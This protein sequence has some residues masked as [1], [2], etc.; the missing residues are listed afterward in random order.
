MGVW[1]EH[2]R[3][4]MSVVCSVQQEQGGHE[5]QG[6]GWNWVRGPCLSQQVR[7]NGVCLE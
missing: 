2:S 4:W 7:G 6:R 3:D 5:S 1:L